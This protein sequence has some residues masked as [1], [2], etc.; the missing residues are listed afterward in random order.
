[1]RYPTTRKHRDIS[2]ENDP[3]PFCADTLVRHADSRRDKVIDLLISYNN[4]IYL[5]AAKL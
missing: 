5:S 2:M 4:K 1:M 3:M